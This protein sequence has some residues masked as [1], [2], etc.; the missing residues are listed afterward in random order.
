M[1]LARFSPDAMWHNPA[2]FSEVC[3][4]PNPV[5]SF[6]VRGPDTARLR[7]FYNTVFDWQMFPYGDAY[8]GVETTLH[9]HDGSTGATTYVGADA[10][11]N[12]GIELADAEGRRGWR[13]RGETQYHEFVPG[14]AGGIA[15]APR[16]SITFYIQVKDL[17]AHPRENRAAWRQDAPPAGGS[18]AGRRAGG[19][20]R[21]GRERDRAEP[22]TV[23]LA[24]VVPCDPGAT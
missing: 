1:C 19:V 9:T 6:E 24:S 7:E 11:L 2:S 8:T 21:S 15:R 5:V 10:H 20:R 4:M 14:I 23:G 13:F 16:P 22:R 18:S 3:R 12:A 17:E